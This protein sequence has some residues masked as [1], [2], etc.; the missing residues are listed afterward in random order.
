MGPRCDPRGSYLPAGCVDPSCGS[1]AAGVL[2]A[3]AAA[4]ECFPTTTT[5]EGFP[6]TEIANQS[7]CD[8]TGNAFTGIHCGRRPKSSNT[9]L[10]AKPPPQKKASSAAV[11]ASG[12]SS[13]QLRASPA[14]PLAKPP[15]ADEPA[16]RGSP[17]ANGLLGRRGVSATGRR[18]AAVRYPPPRRPCRACPAWQWGILAAS[19]LA[20]GSGGSAASRRRRGLCAAEPSRRSGR[21]NRPGDRPPSACPARW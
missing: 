11:A 15:G 12:Q 6:E 18:S 2:A 9:A 13:G 20:V 21:L 7:R 19:G 14:H 3:P 5:T 17:L 8:S 4:N 10:A 16:L 1:L